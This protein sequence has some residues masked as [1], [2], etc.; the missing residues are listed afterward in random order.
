MSGFWNSS[1]SWNRTIARIAIGL[2]G[3]ALLRDHFHSPNEKVAIAVGQAPVVNTMPSSTTVASPNLD[4]GSPKTLKFSLSLASPNDLKIKRG[5]TVAGG[6]VIADR[7]GERTRLTAERKSLILS[8]KKIQGSKIITPLAP[9]AIPSGAKLPPISYAEEEKVI[10]STALLVRQ[11]QRELQLQQSKLKSKPL[12]ESSAVNQAQVNVTKQQHLLDIQQRKIDA[13]T[14]MKDLPPDV[15]L[16]E[17]EVLKQKES[18]LAQANVELQQAQAKVE[19]ASSEQADKLQRLTEAVEK[20]NSEH[21]L[22]ISK[23]QTAHYKRAYQEYEYSITQARHAE[24]RNQALQNH[25]RQLLEAEQHERDRSFQV[26]QIQAKIAE[27]DNQLASLSVIKSPY[28][29]TVQRIRFN[30]QNDKN[31]F[32]EVILVVHN[33][34]LP[35][36]PSL[37]TDSKASTTVNPAW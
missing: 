23:L 9:L 16:H 33:R 31:L 14:A 35:S 32:V 30:G 12:Q 10:A 18:D 8:L 25:Q 29:G 26:A 7:A 2:I 6:Q 36:N 22:A 20:A 24:E 1:D 15:L 34:A 3:L 11:A 27:S 5:D 19:T 17:Q 13:V 37:R 28:P 21:Q 4:T